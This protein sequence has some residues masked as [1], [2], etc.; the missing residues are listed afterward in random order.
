MVED[1]TVGGIDFV[2]GDGA[3]YA[4]I[5]GRVTTTAGEPVSDTVVSIRVWSA[6]EFAP[7][8]I[9]KTDKNGYYTA[10]TVD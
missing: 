7:F 10:A 8:F 9:Q 2:I 1:E 5:R 3:D 6:D 4:Q